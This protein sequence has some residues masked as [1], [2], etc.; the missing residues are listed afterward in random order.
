MLACVVLGS[1]V[2]VLA[3]LVIC[4]RECLWL[5][6]LRVLGKMASYSEFEAIFRIRCSQIGMEKP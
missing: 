4:G 3:I 2:A 1:L 5:Q 6:M